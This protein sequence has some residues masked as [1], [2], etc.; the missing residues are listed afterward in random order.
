[1]MNQS[2][3]FN[4]GCPCNCVACFGGTSKSV[5]L[6][7]CLIVSLGPNEAPGMVTPGHREPV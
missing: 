1:M 2:S 4:P 5:N 7:T 6:K 3:A